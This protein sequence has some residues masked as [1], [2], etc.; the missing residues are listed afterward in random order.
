MDLD[1]AGA[2]AARA[3]P[4]ER[5]VTRRVLRESFIVVVWK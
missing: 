5:A 2:G 3:L 1:S 4:A